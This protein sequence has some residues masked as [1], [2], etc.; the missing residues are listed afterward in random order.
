M[1]HTIINDTKAHVTVVLIV[2]VLSIRIH[3]LSNVSNH[4]GI[5]TLLDDIGHKRLSQKF[6]DYCCNSFICWNI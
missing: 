3:L 2:F 6:V 5:E 4:L 1:F